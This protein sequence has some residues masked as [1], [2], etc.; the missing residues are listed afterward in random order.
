MELAGRIDDFV[1]SYAL[2]D[3][4]EVYYFPVFL[5]DDPQLSAKFIPDE[6][7]TTVFSEYV[8]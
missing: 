8:L 6:W 7:I 1:L 2:Q 4:S 5:I 3:P